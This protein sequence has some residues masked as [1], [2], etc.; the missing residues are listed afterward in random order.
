MNAIVVGK[1]APV[2]TVSTI[3]PGRVVVCDAADPLIARNAITADDSARP[4]LDLGLTLRLIVI[5]T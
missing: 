4:R 2:M 1:L 5:T 3:Y